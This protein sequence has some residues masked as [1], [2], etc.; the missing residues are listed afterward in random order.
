MKFKVLVKN[1]F[2]IVFDT[3]EKARA[4]RQKLRDLKYKSI[5]IRVEQD[6]I[7]P[8]NKEQ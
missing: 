6:D 2:E 5:V 3:I 8:Y 4:F 1:K 7:N